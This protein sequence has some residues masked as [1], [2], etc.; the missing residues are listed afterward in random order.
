MNKIKIF[1]EEKQSTFDDVIT[2][3]DTVCEEKIRSIVSTYDGSFQD[4]V[5]R[6][7]S[8]RF[9]DLEFFPWSENYFD[10]NNPNTYCTGMEIY[11]SFFFRAGEIDGLSVGGYR[12]VSLRLS[13]SHSISNLR[14]DGGLLH[15]KRPVNF[16][17]ISMGYS[18][19]ESVYIDVLQRRYDENPEKFNASDYFEVY[20]QKG[21]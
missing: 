15:I 1:S 7:Y 18:S 17:S 10:Q 13:G 21:D 8:K 19:G 12:N 6:L 3:I 11:A 16:S 4:L 5:I 14:M 20:N 9:G 2:I